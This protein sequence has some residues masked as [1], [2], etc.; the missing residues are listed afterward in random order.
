MK[1]LTE[2][3]LPAARFVGLVGILVLKELTEAVA[4]QKTNIIASCS[5]TPGPTY[6][7]AHIGKS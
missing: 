3:G 2:R 1:L 4:L 6:L 5:L 7:D